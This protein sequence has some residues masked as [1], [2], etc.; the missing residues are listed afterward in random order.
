MIICLSELFA[1]WLALNLSAK[2]KYPHD[3][4]IQFLRW[5]IKAKVINYVQELHQ[6][7]I[8]RV[9]GVNI[10][11]FVTDYPEKKENV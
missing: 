3:V 7:T 5:L 4:L 10:F 8:A 1:G 2:Q 11:R 9:S 6:L